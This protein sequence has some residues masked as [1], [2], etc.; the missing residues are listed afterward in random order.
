MSMPIDTTC[1]VVYTRGMT[2]A[3]NFAP[4][5]AGIERRLAALANLYAAELVSDEDRR[6]VSRS[7]DML[8]ADAGNLTNAIAE[9]DA[10]DRELFDRAYN[11]TIEIERLGR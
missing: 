3:L 1:S 10:F 7:R 4:R 11:A 6:A 5:V 9:Q 8:A 2:N